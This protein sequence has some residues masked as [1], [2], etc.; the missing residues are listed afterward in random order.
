MK[1]L[2]RWL[3]AS[4]ALLLLALTAICSANRINR[5]V[6]SRA[7]TCTACIRVDEMCSYCADEGFE[8]VRCN[9]VEN[10][11]SQ[12]CGYRIEMKSTT[13]FIEAIEINESLKKSQVYPQKMY[14]EL[15][16]GAEYNFDVQV[17]EPLESPVDL[18]I[19]MDF[20]NS[21]SDDLENLKRLGHSLANATEKLSKDYTIGFGKFVDKVSVPQTDMRPAKL[22]EPWPNSDPPF[23]FKNVIP[24]TSDSDRFRRELQ[25]EKISGNLDA[26][27][28]GFDAILQ[29]AACKNHIGWRHDST[30]LLVF[31]TESA[32]HYEADG[33]NVLDGILTRNDEKCHLDANGTYTHDILQD[34]PSVP[35][36]IRMLGKNNIIPIFAVTD[37]S[38]SYYEK[39]YKYFPIAH[40]GRLEED[41]S[42][43]IELLTDAFKEI[44]YKM[45]MHADYVPKSMDAK[46]WSTKAKQTDESTFVVNPG[47]RGEFKARVKAKE[48][49]SPGKHVCELPASD[50]QGRIL[51]KPSTFPNGLEID[52]SI[53]CRACPCEES[54]EISSPKCNYHG[55]MVCGECVCHPGWLGANCNCSNANSAETLPCIRPGT[56]EPCSGRGKCLCGKCHCISE[57]P[58]EKYEGEFCEYS[59]FQCERN[60]G[61][62]CND[63]GRCLLGQCVCDL[64]WTG[65]GCQCPTSNVTCIDS[66]GGLCNGR[67]TC[68]CGKCECTDP[69]FSGTNCEPTDMA[70][71]LGMCEESR[72]CVQCWGWNT[73][74][75]KGEKCKECTV[76]MQFVDEL[77]EVNDGDEY[78]EFRDEDDDCTFHYNIERNPIHQ[79]VT[80]LVLKKKDCPPGGFLWL[81]P[82]LIFLML[83]L[84]LLALLCWKYCACCKACLALLPCCPK[85]RMVGF[86]E[87]HYMLRQSLLT[88][89]HL[90]TPMVRTGPLK[91]SDHVVWKINDNV[92]RSAT[93]PQTIN[94]KEIVQYLIS[95]RLTRLFTENLS[96][97]DNRESDLLKKEVEENLN[98]IYKQIPGAQKLQRTKFRLQPNSGKKHDHTI[99]DTVLA[100]PRAAQQDIVNVTEK[101]VSL[102]AFN[103]LKVSPGYYTVA[104]DK[105]AQGMVEFQEGVE[106]VDVRVPLFIKDEDDDEKHLR[107]EAVDVPFGIAEIGRRFVNITV[108]KEQAKN[109]ISFVQPAYTYNR[110]DKV[111][112]IPIIR[113]IIEDGR[114]QITY[115]TRDLT[116][117]DGKDYQFTEGDLIFLPG[118]TRKEVPVKLLELTEMDNLLDGRVVKQ[119]AMDLSNPRFGAKIGK[120]PR[121]TVTIADTHEPGLVLFKKAF[122]QFS[123]Y[124]TQYPI[125]VIRTK[126]QDGPVVVHWKTL[127]ADRST[128][129]CYAGQSGILRFNDG[130]TERNI[131]FD[132]AK[133]HSPLKP[134]SFQVVMHSPEGGAELGERQ[135]TL[136][137]ILPEE[138]IEQMQPNQALPNL[139]SPKVKPSV[140]TNVTAQSVDPRK[141][142]MLWAPPAGKPTGYKVKYWIEGDP[143]AN[144][145]II[146]TKNPPVE[147]TDLYPY[148]DY[149]M[150]VCGYNSLGEGPYSNI[151][152]CRT[153]EDVPSEPGRL[154]FNVISSTVTQLS[155]AEPAEPN[156]EITAY[157]VSYAPVNEEN[158]LIGPRKMININDPKKRMVLIENLQETQPYCYT[159]RAKNRV[160]WGPEKE[161]TMNLA[162]QPKRPMSIP[163]IPDVPII[164]AEGNEEYENYLMYSTDVL[165]S[166]GA[167]AK[168]PSVADSSGSQWNFV[169]VLGDDLDLRKIRWRL[170]AEEI[171]RYSD[172]SCFSSDA[173]MGAHSSSLSAYSDSDTSSYTPG[174]E[175]RKR[176]G[177]A[178]PQQDNFAD[179]RYEF[180]FPGGGG[181]M[182]KT[183]T[184]NYRQGT[185]NVHSQMATIGGTSVTKEYMT[186]IMSGPDPRLPPGVPD[187][188]TRLVFS[189]LGP[190][191]LKV[192]WQEPQCEKQVLG[193][194]VLYHL[195]SG[196][197]MKRIDVPKSSENS[198]VV[199]SLL[200]NHSYMFKVKAYSDEGW[201]PEREGVIT[202]ESQVDPQSPLTP[203]PGSPFTLSTPSAPGPLVFTALSP[204]S[205]Q[206]SWEKPRKP[207]GTILGY[208]VTCETLHGGGD[209]RTFFV[210]GDS[211]E[212]TLTVPDLNENVPYKFKVQAKTTQGFGPE[213]EGIITIESQDGGNLSQFSN[214]QITRR[215]VF[216]I[217][218]EMTTKTTVTHT[219]FEDPMFS[220]G[221]M[222]MTGQRMEGGSTITKQVVTKT[223]VSG[224]TVTK[225]TERK[226]FDA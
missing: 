93:Y 95:L 155:W 183:I 69:M 218:G 220:D 80:I 182:T 140:P 113:D 197:D 143:E 115:R 27:E 10:L 127:S 119:F 123:P 44:R 193:Y 184:T 149:E 36:L 50:Q 23:S 154:A 153:L 2:P 81:I 151:V 124:D 103:E 213:R 16:A 99:V 199:D 212:T 191:S 165:R 60:A 45:E 9:L 185:P 219:T 128:P 202:I 148:C 102:Q 3:M 97:P 68:E 164:D 67:G 52:A 225:Q 33:A 12:G 222:M 180:N 57:N 210:E 31:S 40:I 122:Q 109:I 129:S 221:M 118:E 217:P 116:A 87:D 84:G 114:T 195:L 152:R 83:L 188:P 177:T 125:P 201:G 171:P 29:V 74:E 39:L 32:F 71:L 167:G 26:P 173:E 181:T 170:P 70:R 20:S 215:E 187:T 111:A 53:I 200:P 21:M 160:G 65:T 51:I 8:H 55:D 7:K 120:Y 72:T 94:P 24:L 159:V 19:L 25:K 79:N 85:G 158:Q 48:E 46:I 206:L 105:D 208:M 22:N 135:A 4:L 161:A 108:I 145:H 203:V 43:L 196:G 176:R 132:T 30:H 163:I 73:G 130:E 5:C 17:F 6:A 62:L 82:L 66:R 77:K 37:Y 192:S 174:N 169:H 168:R 96:K 107:V 137:T 14:M 76:N 190:T 34:Y 139:Q 131:V 126:G 104:S 172:S 88:S 90:D 178:R 117:K 49:A 175:N 138:N 224:G 41:S 59:N 142:R 64:G 75:K 61:F 54:K 78:C 211:A 28:G 189:A 110:H 35:T 86:K 226:F 205:L 166:P 146:D 13:R 1:R 147:L 157:E 121:T 144:A 18:Y 15:R 58:L 38:Y 216:N 186:N 42:N 133:G 47:E 209:A 11:I 214:Q 101:N 56:Q 194:Q 136:V 150:R 98:E 156:G 92:H 179:G 207:N 63:R 162:T 91:G 106:S 112:K 198:V 89:D 204:D 100:A 223:M 134:E 141:I